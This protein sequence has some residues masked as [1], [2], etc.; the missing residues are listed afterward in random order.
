MTFFGTC[1]VL[2]GMCIISVV[3]LGT[4]F[5]ATLYGF[6][7]EDA[8]CQKGTRGGINLSDWL[9]GFGMEK[10][11][12]V[13]LACI[14][15]AFS[16]CCQ[17]F[18]YIGGTISVIDILFTIAWAIW[19]IV[20]L[21]TGENNDCVAEGHEMAIMAIIDIILCWVSFIYLFVYISIG[22]FSSSGGHFTNDP[23]FNR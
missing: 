14:S 8:S 12:I 2:C 20:I 15:L 17:A 9:K 6:G 4:A 5:P 13:V 7:D 10:I 1:G 23:F 16:Q 21:A 22:F 19:G 18:T 11:F 3:V